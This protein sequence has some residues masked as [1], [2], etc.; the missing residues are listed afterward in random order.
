MGK[1]AQN[2]GCGGPGEWEQLFALWGIPW[3]PTRLLSRENLG[4]PW[5]NLHLQHSVKG[6]AQQMRQSQKGAV[7]RPL[8]V[9]FA[10]RLKTLRE[11]KEKGTA[12]ISAWCFHP[13]DCLPLWESLP[14]EHF[15][16]SKASPACENSS[17]CSELTQKASPSYWG[18]V[19]P[20][21][22]G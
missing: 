3:K 11:E 5:W 14:C 21:Q 2:G 4:N 9:L 13:L 16:R 19:E 7:L 20:F 6:R 17:L 1:P 12:A 18:S 15:K 8:K 10:S 22:V